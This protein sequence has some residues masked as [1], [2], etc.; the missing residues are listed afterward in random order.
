MSNV[1]MSLDQYLFEVWGT[2]VDRASQKDSW[3]WVEH[4]TAVDIPDLEYTGAGAPTAGLSGMIFPFVYG[5]L[6]AIEKLRN[7]G[8]Q[9]R[10]M[11]LMDGT[12]KKWGHYVITGLEQNNE[13]LAM[14]GIPRKITWRLDLKKFPTKRVLPQ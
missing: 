13:S 10:P 14:D 12:G 3:N 8:R 11:I 6:G 7:L 9:A 4:E 2:N 1:L 5:E